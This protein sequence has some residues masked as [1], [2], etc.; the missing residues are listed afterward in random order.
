MPNVWDNLNTA[1]EADRAA[2]EAAIR[3][4]A[5]NNPGTPQTPP[6]P[7]PVYN[8]W[9]PNPNNPAGTIYPTDGSAYLRNKAQIVALLPKY[10]AWQNQWNA[11]TEKE[12]RRQASAA[13]QGIPYTP[14]P[15]NR[16]LEQGFY[17]TRNLLR[18]MGFFDPSFRISK[19][20]LTDDT[21]KQAWAEATK[22]VV[23]AAPVPPPRGA[24]A[25]QAAGMEALGLTPP[26]TD[27][28]ATTQ[29]QFG[30]PPR[31]T[32]AQKSMENFSDIATDGSETAGTE[33]SK[34]SQTMPGT[35][36]IEIASSI[37]S[38]DT[39]SDPVK[40]V[41]DMGTGY[42]KTD[43]VTGVGQSGNPSNFSWSEPA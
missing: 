30:K 28:G 8:A 39:K 11:Y 7:P 42:R 31:G 33:S 13:A 36:S 5:Q 15:P 20:A 22:P 38:T 29:S 9:N 26:A 17:Q 1:A 35:S 34:T 16:D 2:G 40:S 23:P 19:T 43:G 37:P 32:E 24:L 18:D 10:V 41:S 25:K 14:I 4:N 27:T 6:A 21:I 12:K 3:E